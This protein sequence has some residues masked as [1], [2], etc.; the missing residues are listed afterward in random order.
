MGNKEVIRVQDLDLMLRDLR[1]R[2]VL[3]IERDDRVG[4]TN[5]GC[6]QHVPVVRI[7]Q[8]QCWNQ[9]LMVFN[10]SIFNGI[11]HERSGV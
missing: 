7:R 11:G 2:K 1:L 5:D 3:E 10:Q 4:M 8:V 6:R 9:I